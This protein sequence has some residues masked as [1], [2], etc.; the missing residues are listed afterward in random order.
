MNSVNCLLNKSFSCH[1]LEEKLKIKELGRQ[2]PD[3][4]INQTI[5]SK[6]RQF[7]RKFNSDVYK[8]HT[9]LC[10]CT[11]KNAL[12]CFPCLL[13]GGEE[14][15]T[16]LGTDDINHLSHRISK[17]ERSKIHMRNV[18]NLTVFGKTSIA[19][20]L[21]SAYRKTIDLHNQTVTHNRYILNLIINCI[22]FCGAFELALR[23]HDESESSSNPGV[24]RGLINF[25]A[26]LDSALKSHLDKSTVFKGTSKTIQ[27]EL[28]QCML[29][30]SQ[31]QI[32]KEIKEAEFL[33]V[34][35]DETSDIACI[36]QIVIV[37]RY[38][39]N[40]KPVERFWA[41]LNPSNH[42]A[43]SLAS[44]ILNQLGHHLKD[45]EHK[46]IAQTYDGASVMR[47]C[48]FFSMSPQRTAILDAIVKKR[49]PQSVPTRWNFHS[50]SVNTV[51]EYREQLIECMQ[52]ILDRNEIANSNTLAQASGQLEILKKNTFIF[53]LTFFHKIMPHVDM[54]FNQLQK[55]EI[56][57][58]TA[59][60]NIEAFEREVSRIRNSMT[61]D[62]YN[63]TGH[64]VA[65]SLFLQDKFAHYDKQFPENLLKSTCECYPILE[66]E[67]RSI[68]GALCLFQFMTNN[69]VCD[70]FSE[71]VK[72]LKILITIPMTST[73][74]ERCFS[75]LKRIKTF[76]RNSMGQ[77]RLAALAM[78]SIEKDFI[79]QISDFNG[80][81]IEKFSQIKNRR[82]DFLFK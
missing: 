7:H 8:K 47:I 68:S 24:F 49:L 11:V 74:A 70:T 56:D 67:F 81:V 35:A 36:Y 20:E 6:N 18:M 45:N 1:T 77:E 66:T 15:W 55:R 42:N 25:S 5:K 57:S 40:G 2:T 4:V 48:T 69:N 79:M 23:G 19:L 80:K 26:E 71:C 65:A 37:Y 53:W 46:L 41:F 63:F 78:L 16:R 52:A 76:L 14:L 62:R 21:D 30:V 82:M 44:I 27:N 9:W 17:H 39:V 72:L 60:G 22:R 51:F 50:R 61:K 58:V 43:A 10:G 29:E 13:F 73:E 12:F 64:L 33:A 32:S 59:K 31:E 75:T 54:L 28:L 3:L 38:I 34:I